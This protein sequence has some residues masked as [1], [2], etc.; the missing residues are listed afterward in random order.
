MIQFMGWKLYLFFK[1]V[2]HLFFISCVLEASKSMKHSWYVSIWWICVSILWT[3]SEHGIPW[4]HTYKTSCKHFFRYF[5]I[6]TRV[7][8]ALF[9][10]QK[11]TIWLSQSRLYVSN[12]RWRCVLLNPQTLD[13]QTPP[14]TWW[15]SVFGTRCLGIQIAPQLVF[16]CLV[17]KQTSP[18]KVFGPQKPRLPRRYLFGGLREDVLFKPS[19]SALNGSVKR[20]AKFTI[21]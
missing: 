4:I 21:L 12:L 9:S 17:A 7:I 14:N 5:Y 6:Y 2:G 13:T 10:A 20:S 15:G 8:L 1:R 18:E 3:S 19:S 16:G 11:I